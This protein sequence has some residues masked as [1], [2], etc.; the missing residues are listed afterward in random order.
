MLVTR[1]VAGTEDPNLADLQ[2]LKNLRPSLQFVVINGAT[3]DGA[4]GTLNRV[5]FI[6]AVEKVLI[7]PSLRY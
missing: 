3:H 7:G 6:D 2:E 4:R 5:E 1:W